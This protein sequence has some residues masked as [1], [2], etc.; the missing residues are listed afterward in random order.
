[1]DIKQLPILLLVIHHLM[2]IE[3]QNVDF[4]NELSLSFEH[5]IV[6]VGEFLWKMILKLALARGASNG[7]HSM[8]AKV[9]VRW[10]FKIVF[11]GVLSDA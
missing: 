8:I 5:Q 6:I 3:L 1:M 4:I 10:G 7:D 11:H 9:G 2:Q